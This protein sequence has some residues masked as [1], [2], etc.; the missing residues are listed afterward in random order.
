L[1]SRANE[2]LARHRMEIAALGTAAFVA[3]VIVLLLG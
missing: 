1:D 3:V 2:L